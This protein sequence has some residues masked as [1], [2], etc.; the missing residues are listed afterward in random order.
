MSESVEIDQNRRSLVG[1][2][3]IGFVPVIIAWVIFFYFPGLMPS[4][5]TNEGDLIA[6]PVQ[7]SVLGLEAETGRWTL[8]VPITQACDAACDERFYLARQVNVALGKESDRVHR[9]MADLGATPTK[10]EA[11]MMEY[12]SLVRVPVAA[13]DFKNQ[14]SDTQSIYLM[15]PI[16]NIFMVY[17]QEKAGKPML[18]DIKHLLKI[19]NIG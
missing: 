5:T 2:F 13:S 6:P 17:D 16:G 4:G 3:G 8:I 10:I 1:L 14:L 15:D 9:V 19:S 7:A 18:K 11:L 12:P